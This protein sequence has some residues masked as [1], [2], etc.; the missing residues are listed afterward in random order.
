MKVST[1]MVHNPSILLVNH[2]I[3]MYVYYLKALIVTATWFSIGNGL[4]FGR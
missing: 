4:V 3:C 2:K 1:P